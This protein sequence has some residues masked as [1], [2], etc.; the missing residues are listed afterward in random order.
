MQPLPTV[1]IILDDVDLEVNSTYFIVLTECTQKPLGIRY[2]ADRRKEEGG[3]VV[4]VFCCGYCA[5]IYGM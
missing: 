3:N 5:G 1:Y 2:L 4:R